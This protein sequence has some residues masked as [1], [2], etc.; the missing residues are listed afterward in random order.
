[1]LSEA[2]WGDREDYEGLLHDISKVEV[3]SYYRDGSM[4]PVG[5]NAV[6]EFLFGIFLSVLGKTKKTS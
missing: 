2:L 4:L 1:M 3:N 5:L 6:H